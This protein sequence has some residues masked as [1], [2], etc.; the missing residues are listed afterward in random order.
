VRASRRVCVSGP[1]VDKASDYR[2]A[3][4]ANIRCFGRAEGGCRVRVSS[5][6]DARRR[7]RRV[8]RTG[9]P[10]HETHSRS[11][12]VQNDHETA[13]T[14]VPASE[15]QARCAN[16]EHDR[17][18]GDCYGSRASTAISDTTAVTYVGAAVVAINGPHAESANIIKI[19]RASTGSGA[20]T[21]VTLCDCKRSEGASLT[22]RALRSAG[23][24]VAGVMAYKP[25]AKAP[26]L[27]AARSLA[28][29]SA[30]REVAVWPSAE[31]RDRFGNIFR[32]NFT[33]DEA[34]KIAV[35]L[36]LQ[37]RKVRTATRPRLAANR[38]IGLIDVDVRCQSPR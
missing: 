2:E 7:R 20:T 17:F 29:V 26:T 10:R 11:W 14:A 5:A 34:R 21:A 19:C 27:L 6:G 1:A 13:E 3:H 25:P 16:R 23:C 33:S 24:N 38:G 12:R 28:V 32:T 15:Q 31:L 36:V 9:E 8:R 35:R 30:W 37:D 22:K 18:R 4:C